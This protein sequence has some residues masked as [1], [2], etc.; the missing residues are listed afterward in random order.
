MTSDTRV[1]THAVYVEIF[2]V[3]IFHGLNF[4]GDKFLRVRVA[5]RN[6]CCYFFVCTN[7]LGFDFV[8]VACPRKLFPNENFCV[9]GTQWSNTVRGCG[10]GKE[11]SQWIK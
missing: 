1:C 2:V 11:D 10:H 7:F 8:G 5:H 9:Y 4:L 6:Y 3:T